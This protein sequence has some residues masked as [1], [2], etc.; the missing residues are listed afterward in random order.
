VNRDARA[1]ALAAAASAG[2]L[3]PARGAL[4]IGVVL[5]PAAA[6]VRWPALR[7]LAVALLASGLAQRSL[8][9][10]GGLEPGLVVGEV[11]LLSDP[12][13]HFEGVRV[14]VRWG[15]RRLEAQ[16]RGVSA[17]ALRPRLAGE[18]V[19]LRGTV[20][21]VEPGRPWLV[22]RH[23]AGELSV[24]RVDTWRAG[25]PA[26]RIANALRRTLVTGAA[27]L[28]ARSRSL[29]TGL[30]IGDDREQPADLADAFRGAGLTHLLAVSG[31]NVAFALALAGPL[32]R[33]LRLWPRLGATLGVIGLFG[34]M[35]RFEPS[36]LRASAMAALA[37]TLAMP[38]VPISRLRVVG[39]AVT[40]LVLIDP[41]LVRS[42][43]FQLS[44][45][46]AVAIVVLTPR[47]AA[48][49]PGPAALRE[50]AAVTLAAQ[51]GVAPVLLATFGPVPV[52]SLPA[53]LLCVPVAGLVMIWGLTGGLVAGVLGAPV[54]ELVHQPTRLALTWLELVADRTAHAPLGELQL[55]QVV[56]LAGGLAVAVLAVSR[57]GLRHLGGTVAVGAVLSA[58]VVAHTPA[59]LR[60]AV[61]PGVVRWHARGVDVV[62]LGGA[63]GRSTLAGA[64]VLEALRR[65]GVGTIDVLV[66]ADPS[67]P[68]SVVELVRGAHRTSATHGIA[69]G[70]ATI[71]LGSLVVRIVS[72]PGRLVV[73]AQPRGP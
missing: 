2:A 48:A 52:A 16:A 51:L 13:P 3:V 12:T 45:C 10:L 37:A 64:S 63:G 46:A 28:D 27:P 58:V 17:D 5:V 71:D 60:D 31:Q 4:S 11:T 35:T 68:A 36:V 41:L 39:L 18:V 33:R 25:D 6:L 8:D 67:V 47:L 56:G 22:A 66:V 19:T 42:A 14:D 29:F 21:P 1:L 61:S 62:V 15:H 53:N 57:P 50:A 54:A 73:D 69:D 40:A 70:A 9:G 55:L 49:L 44:V 20:R 32:L 59:P 38:G 23:I 26:S 34:V 7:W 24:H 65:S 43:G 30:V 72:V